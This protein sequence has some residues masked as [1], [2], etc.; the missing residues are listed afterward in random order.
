MNTNTISCVH[1]YVCLYTCTVYMYPFIRTGISVRVYL[2]K[3]KNLCCNTSLLPWNPSIW[4]REEL[5]NED[6]QN[7][8]K[9]QENGKL[10]LANPKI[11]SILSQLSRLQSRIEVHRDS[12]DSLWFL[13]PRQRVVTTQR[14]P[15]LCM[16]FS[17][18]EPY[19]VWLLCGIR[20]AIEGVQCIVAIL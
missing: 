1:M 13:I 16:S 9:A 3:L 11:S 18:K 8:C 10:Y 17:A 12:D 20:P 6:L 7:L 15:Y 5:C 2:N 19:N 14:M 4:S